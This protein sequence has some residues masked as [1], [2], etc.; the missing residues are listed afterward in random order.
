LVRYE[1][2]AGRKGEHGSFGIIGIPAPSCRGCMQPGASNNSQQVLVEVRQHEED[3]IVVADLHGVD[4]E[5]VTLR[6]INPGL[7]EIAC[8][9][10]QNTRD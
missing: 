4:K 10:E 6:L 8:T 7:L 1:R 5:W 9:D 3:E 2:H